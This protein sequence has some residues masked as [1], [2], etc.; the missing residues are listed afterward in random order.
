[1]K[2]RHKIKIKLSYIAIAFLLLL[3]LLTGLVNQTILSLGM[4][5]CYLL[6]FLDGQLYLAFPFLIFYYSTYGLLFGISVPRI[7][8]ILLLADFLVKS[9]GKLKVKA[10]FLFPLLVYL[11]YILNFTIFQESLL[12][13]TTF[14]DIIIC[15]LLIACLN[16]EKNIIEEFFTVYI[17][18]SFCSIITGVLTENYIGNEFTYHRFQASFEDPNYAG[19]FFTIAVFSAITLNLFNKYLRVA[20]VALLYIAI[21]ATLSITA[22]LVNLVAWVSYFLVINKIKFRTILTIVLAIIAVLC[23]YNYGLKNKDAALV[24]EFSARV[25]EKVDDF[26]LGDMEKATTGRTELWKDNLE[27]YSSSKIGNILFGGIHVNGRYINPSLSGASHNDFVDMLLNVGIIGMLV[28]MGYYMYN[29]VKY[30][31]NYRKQ[32]DKYSLFCIMSKLI[33]MYY[34]T[35]LTMFLDF[36]FALFFLL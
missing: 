17:L 36:R 5:F 15:F 27:Y 19:F 10:K 30:I 35:G 34:A 3:A 28:L 7:Y 8:T 6:L 31:M 23:L 32:K 21:I 20:I 4:V 12:L 16:D 14:L 24:G 1:M 11:F 22:M 2:K 26:I 9:A 18:V 13:I 33:W 29:C 25:K